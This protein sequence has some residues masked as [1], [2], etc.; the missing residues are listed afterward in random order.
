MKV[1]YVFSAR[2]VVV[3]HQSSSDFGDITMS[4]MAGLSPFI[5]REVTRDMSALLCCDFFSTLEK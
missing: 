4:L 3:H 2:M 5:A 1:E